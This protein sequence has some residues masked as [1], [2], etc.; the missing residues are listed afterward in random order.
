MRWISCIVFL[1]YGHIIYVYGF[2]QQ[3]YCS[4]QLPVHSAIGSGAAEQQR[5]GA[6]SW[7]EKILAKTD[8]A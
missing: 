7:R 4:C 6:V 8:R 3:T 5:V 1:I 2:M